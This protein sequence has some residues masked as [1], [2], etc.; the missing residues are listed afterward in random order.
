MGKSKA[1]RHGAPYEVVGSSE[2]L[3]EL[4]NISAQLRNGKSPP[5]TKW[6]DRLHDGATKF[7]KYVGIPSLI[8][9]SF[10]PVQN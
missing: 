8:I 10:G 1:K 2:I 3:R 9:A 7:A 4:Q 6:Y 5:S